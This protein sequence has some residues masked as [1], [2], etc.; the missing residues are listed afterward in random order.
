VDASLP[1]SALARYA[2]PR[3]RLDHAIG[4]ASASSNTHTPDRALL[5]IACRAPLRFIV[6]IRVSHL[7]M[8]N[9]VVLLI[10]LVSIAA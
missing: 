1:C 2:R 10:V 9:S 4:H 7:L 5:G 8:R 6:A 3:P